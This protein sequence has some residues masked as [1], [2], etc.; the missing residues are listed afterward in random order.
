MQ[1]TQQLTSTTWDQVCLSL[2]GADEPAPGFAGQQVRQ[3]ELDHRTKQRDLEQ[4]PG[5]A[6]PNSPA[7]T[8]A[9][10]EPAPV[11]LNSIFS[12]YRRLDAEIARLVAIQ[13]DVEER[14]FGQSFTSK[15][16]LEEIDCIAKSALERLIQKAEIAFAPVGGRLSISRNEVMEALKLDDW[17][18]SRSSRRGRRGEAALE[19]EQVVDLEKVQAYL[20]A[21]YGGDAGIR[22]GLSQAAAT[23]IRDFRIK[24]EESVQ[25][26]KSGVILS[27]RVYSTKK[28]YGANSGMYEPYHSGRDQAPLFQA[29]ETF[30]RHAEL[31]QLFNYGWSRSD[32]CNHGFC[33]S[34]RDKRTAPGL[35]ISFFKEE[36]KFKFGPAEAEKLMLFLGEFGQE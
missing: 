24:G 27:I 15:V 32:I 20:E 14:L 12:N 10:T 34:P 30:F 11:N 6:Q 28:D 33:F 25:R 29:L 13:Q 35:E 19:I 3:L 9:L 31:Y 23:I 16:R 26:V 22:R 1:Q 2:D 21:T 17:A 7:T 8:E 4:H 5:L 18:Y 36:W